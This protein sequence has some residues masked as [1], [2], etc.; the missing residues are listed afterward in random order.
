[1]FSN[2]NVEHVDNLADLAQ[3]CDVLVTM[4]DSSHRLGEVYVLSSTPEIDDELVELGQST[5]PID[6]LPV[7]SLRAG[8]VLI[9]VTRSQSLRGIVDHEMQSSTSVLQ[10]ARPMLRFLYA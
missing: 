5:V 4:L 3:D 8:M 2:T 1:M 7:E 10:E 9:D 6:V